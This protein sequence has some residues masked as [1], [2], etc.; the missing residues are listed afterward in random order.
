MEWSSGWQPWYSPETLKLVF[1]VSSEY[2]GCHHDELFHS[3]C[4]GPSAGEV[5]LTDMG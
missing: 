1:N 2:Q 4:D 3:V 5:T